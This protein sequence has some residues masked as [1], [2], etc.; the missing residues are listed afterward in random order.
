MLIKLN[1]S[2]PG[3]QSPLGAGKKSFFTK[4][5]APTAIPLNLG[6]NLIAR[7]ASALVFGT[8]RAMTENDID[9]VIAAFVSAA[10]MAF[11]AGFQ[12]VEVHAGRE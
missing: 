2:H 6:N 1:R 9:R 5:I 8:P 10:N 4:N 12:G 7:C 3:R 11:R